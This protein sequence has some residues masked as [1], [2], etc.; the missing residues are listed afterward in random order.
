MSRVSP[1]I[2]ADLTFPGK[3]VVEALNRAIE[4]YGK[5]KT[6]CVDT[7]TEFTGRVLDLWAHQNG[8]KLQFSRPGKPTDNAMIETFNAKVRAE[9]LNLHWFE[10]LGEA[11]KM[12]ELCRLDYNEQR[13]H[14]ALN[15]HTPYEY[16]NRLKSKKQAQT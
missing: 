4:R 1:G 12:L 11:Q 16:L 2:E 15:G 8:V 14:H 13:P 10:S 6:I 3:Q 5:P 7:G 9:C